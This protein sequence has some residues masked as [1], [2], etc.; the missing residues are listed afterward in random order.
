MAEV[1]PDR[2]LIERAQAELPYGTAAYDEL[3]RKYSPDVYRR[4]YRILRSSPDAEEASQDVF[5]AVYRNLRRFRFEK[6]FSHWLSTITLN[7]CRM[8]LRRRAQE[9]RRR[10]AVAQER[11]PP[12]PPLRNGVLRRVVLELLD[13]LE[14]GTRVAVLLRFVDGYTYGEIA[15][16]LELSES[17]AKMR[18][19]RGAKRLRE[20]YEERA[21]GASA[22][23]ADPTAAE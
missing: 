2:E 13:T 20:L 1:D 22:T 3:V 10:S 8:I 19:S 9:Q 7:A 14:P 21:R 11:P 18:V 12:D 17:A 15:E 4:S 23:D 6:P 16:Q 5:L